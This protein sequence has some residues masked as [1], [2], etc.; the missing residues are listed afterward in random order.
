MYYAAIIVYSSL[1]LH[2]PFYWWQKV[3]GADKTLKNIQNLHSVQHVDDWNDRYAIGVMVPGSFRNS[4]RANP[5]IW[6]VIRDCHI[7]YT[8]CK[9]LYTFTA[10][11]YVIEFYYHCDIVF[12]N[13][14]HIQRHSGTL[15]LWVKLRKE[16]VP[17]FDYYVDTFLYCGSSSLKLK[18]QFLQITD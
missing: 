14:G 4:P 5:L 18:L 10:D 15:H 6:T 8:V 1:S 16:K 13:H 7:A 3:F 9:L 12:I 2:M 11:L 17:T